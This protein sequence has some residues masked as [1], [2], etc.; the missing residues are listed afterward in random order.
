MNNST[1]KSSVQS[2]EWEEIVKSWDTLEP[3]IKAT[4][5]RVKERVDYRGAKCAKCGNIIIENNI[6]LVTLISIPQHPYSD[7]QYLTFLCCT[8][9]WPFRDVGGVS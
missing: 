9:C 8:E 6:G 1:N 3:D 5:Q 2:F 7:L 4:I